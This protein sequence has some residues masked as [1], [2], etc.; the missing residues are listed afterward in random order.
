MTRRETVGEFEATLC[1]DR[2]LHFLDFNSSSAA[3]TCRRRPCYG[4]AR[5]S[6]DLCV[7]TAKGLSVFEIS[8]RRCPNGS[9]HPA[10]NRATQQLQRRGN[11]HK[12]VFGDLVWL[13]SHA[14][15]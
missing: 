9:A 7:R 6:C 12:S 10:T 8:T 15:R 5:P 14:I 11:R 13:H 1:V 2:K 4:P 3:R